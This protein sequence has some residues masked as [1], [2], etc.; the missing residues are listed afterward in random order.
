LNAGTIGFDRDIFGGNPTLKDLK[1][2]SIKVID[3]E[4][5]FLNNEVNALCELMDDYK[6]TEDRD[7]PEEFW[8]A[9]KTQGFFC[10]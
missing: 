2:Y 3:E 1:K 9:C 10:K 4:Q 6:I 8:E 5:K 7:L